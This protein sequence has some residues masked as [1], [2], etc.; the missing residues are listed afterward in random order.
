MLFEANAGKPPELSS[1]PGFKEL[2]ACRQCRV[3]GTVRQAQ[4][5]LRCKGFGRCR[6]QGV[7]LKGCGSRV[8]GCWKKGTRGAQTACPGD[9]FSILGFR[10]G[11]WS[12]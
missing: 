5:V 12:H 6:A 8:E 1:V 11:R 9:T 4:G 10:V 3:Y 2:L 7:N